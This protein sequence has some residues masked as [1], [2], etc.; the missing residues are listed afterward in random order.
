MEPGAL[1]EE[2]PCRFVLPVVPAAR[3]IGKS[4]SSL[5]T[6]REQSGATVRIL[7]K[8]LPHEMQLREDRVVLI[9]GEASCVR[10][11]V[12]G[13]LERVFDRSGLPDGARGSRDR[14]HTVDVL[15]PEKSGAHLIGQRGERIKGLIEET[16]CDINVVKEP[17][18]GLA[19]QKRV[20]VT[21]GSA[22]DVAS[23]VWAVQG[24]LAELF[25]AGVL[26]PSHF[27]LREASD[28]GAAGGRTGLQS[29]AG[30]GGGTREVPIRLLVAKEECA[31]VLGKKG[32]KIARLRDI[33]RVQMN[34]ADSP[35]FDESDRVLE[36]A[37]APLEQRL[38]VVQAVLDDLAL[39]D[40]TSD[41]LHLLAPTEYFGSLMGHRGENIR[42]IMKS[43]GVNLKQ[44]K[45]ERLDD[46]SEYRFRL[47]EIKGE[48]NQRV[49][50]VRLIHLSLE[51][52][53]SSRG[54]AMVAQTV[55]DRVMVPPTTPTVAD[56]APERDAAHA[57]RADN[58]E[59][60]RGRQRGLTSLAQA[61]AATAWS[62]NA[63]G[64]AVSGSHPLREDCVLP[65]PL[66]QARHAEEKTP[67]VAATPGCHLTLQLAM[68]SEEVA[69]MLA[70]ESSGIAWRAG[71]KLAAGRGTGGMPILEVAGTAV[72]N[73]VACYLIQDRLFMMH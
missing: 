15:V 34:D 10:E 68:P 50:A 59:S 5:R 8:E 70:S 56:I 19:E 28:R 12:D 43:T 25:A 58:S 9:T 66:L 55:P 6:I 38:R 46:G 51:A 45:A 48:K 22:D 53:G 40:E 62:D 67:V 21:G 18:A 61:P 44:H 30:G 60:D 69:R 14:V 2:V 72:G 24:V 13:V 23:A 17:I 27:E 16:S 20:R 65:Q 4:G 33:A 31:W 3:V 37:A 71:V 52:R 1:M 7:E 32:N 29:G 39:R 26:K 11:A 42:N 35:P 73:S 47:V 36:I 57:L 41:E 49:D 64:S 63:H 54:A